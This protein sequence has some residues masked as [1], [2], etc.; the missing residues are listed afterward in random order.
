MV[1][2]SEKVEIIFGLLSLQEGVIVQLTKQSPKQGEHLKKGLTE[3]CE[4]AF[5]VWETGN[6]HHYAERANLSLTV[7]LKLQFTAGTP[8]RDTFHF[9]CTFV[10]VWLLPVCG[11]FNEFCQLCYALYLLSKQGLTYLRVP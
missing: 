7:V 4:H 8:H 11:S 5:P 3:S 2:H 1:C 10:C 6:Y 9:S